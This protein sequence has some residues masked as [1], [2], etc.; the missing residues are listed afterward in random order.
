MRIQISSHKVTGSIEVTFRTPTGAET[1]HVIFN[2][3]HLWIGND[4]KVD[5]ALLTPEEEG[6]EAVGRII[7]GK[8]FD[9]VI[10]RVRS[11]LIEAE[12][13]VFDLQVDESLLLDHRA[14]INSPGNLATVDN[15][16]PARTSFEVEFS[17]RSGDGVPVEVVID[18]T[19]EGLRTAVV[20]LPESPVSERIIEPTQARIVWDPSTSEL[21]VRLTGITAGEGRIW[22]RV[23][24]GESGDLLAVDRARVQTDGSAVSSSIVPHN[25][26]LGELYVD[27]TDSPTETIGTSRFRVRRRA[28]RLE[29]FA[30]DLEKGGQVDQASAVRAK[31]QN[32]RATL[33][34]DS[35]VI[36]S[37]QI[38]QKRSKWW[39]GIMLVAVLGALL[40]WLVRGDNASGAPDSQSVAS[41]STDVANTVTLS[42][43]DSSVVSPNDQTLLVYRPGTTRF[44]GEGN[45]NLAAE[46][47]NVVDDSVTVR[48]QLY[49]QYER[50]LGEST[51]ST[52]QG[53]MQ[54]CESRV[55]SDTGSGGG[56]FAL[57]TRVAAFVASTYEDAL[58][59]LA[60]T[61]LSDPDAEY[62]GAVTMTANII[63]SCEVRR[64]ID[65]DSVVE[66]ARSAFESFTLEIPIG[67]RSE[68]YVVL[69]VIND[70]GSSSPW[71]STDVLKI[72]K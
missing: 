38:K 57:Q 58:L 13:T 20:H 47:E 66:I 6:F 69:R 16:S 21:K 29:A 32:L 54:E 9:E 4:Q 65:Q 64:I 43:G 30:A 17:L 27:V 14:L 40:G 61:D 25:G 50:S 23:A 39:V 45:V 3:V 28:A 34:E 19:P 41:S 71:T 36:S 46:V 62:A 72:S 12:E 15:V 60:D 51:T 37:T 31:A 5:C 10:N 18:G 35:G 67:N 44:F 48:V 70:K 1:R 63:E 59:L 2:G 24:L 52:Q 11:N 33:G 7:L 53:L 8:Y 56:A 68:A 22:V 55:G 49:D 26:E 42:P